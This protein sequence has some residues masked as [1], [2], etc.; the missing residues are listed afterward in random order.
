MDAD[1]P[2]GDDVLITIYP[3]TAMTGT[4]LLGPVSVRQGQVDI[5]SLGAQQ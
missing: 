1:I 4:P 3:T 5:S 2:A